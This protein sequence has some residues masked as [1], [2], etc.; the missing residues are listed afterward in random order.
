MLGVALKDRISNDQWRQMWIETIANLKWNRVGHAAKFVDGLLTRLILEWTDTKAGDTLQRDGRTKL[1]ESL[2]TGS[3][4]PRIG[5]SGLDYAR[6]MFSS[7]HKWVDD[8]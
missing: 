5:K 2:Q 7:G 4:S 3:M 8:D 1:R 6:P